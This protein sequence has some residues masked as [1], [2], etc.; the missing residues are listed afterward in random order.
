MTHLNKVFNIGF[1]KS[2]TTSL[3]NAMDI[4]G[5]KSIHWKL[6]DDRLTDI[7]LE[8][9]KAGRDLLIGLEQFEFLSDFSGDLF[10]KDLDKQCPGSKFILTVRDMDSWL[11]SRKKHVIRN[12]NNPDYKYNFLK[13]DIEGWKTHRE[14]LEKEIKEYFKDRPDDLLIIDILGGDGWDKLCKFLS[15]EVPKVPFPN[16]NKTK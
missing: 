3:A 5:Y 8:N 11:E 15:K 12:Q 9:R 7:M 6:G 4:L 16:L 10:Y 13:V 1:N 2:G 14:R